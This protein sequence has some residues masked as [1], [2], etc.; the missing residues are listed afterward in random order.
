MSN[1]NFRHIY[2][3]NKCEQECTMT[4]A[5]DI[6]SRCPIPLGRF[7]GKVRYRNPQWIDVTFG[8]QERRAVCPD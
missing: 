6:P 3:C 4:C 2:L 1:N 8:E 5:D 7:Q